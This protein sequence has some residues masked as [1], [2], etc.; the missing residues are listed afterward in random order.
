MQWKAVTYLWC[1]GGV[2]AAHCTHMLQAAQ[3][4]VLL[5]T[6]VA[7]MWW[8]GHNYNIS[9]SSELHVDTMKVRP[10]A[11]AW[12]TTIAIVLIMIW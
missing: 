3:Q 4:V 11:A 7:A 1:G 5:S 2:V 8:S 9:S 12:N 6:A 10:L